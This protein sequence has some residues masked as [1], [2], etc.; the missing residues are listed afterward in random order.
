MSSHGKLS[1]V[2]YSWAV[3]SGYT[4]PAFLFLS[5]FLSVVLSHPPR[6]CLLRRYAL[7]DSREVL[8][9]SPLPLHPVCTLLISVFLGDD[10]PWLSCSLALGGD[11]LCMSLLLMRERERARGN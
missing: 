9:M 2:L 5:S 7:S 3:L 10:S 1:I 8:S 4:S 11:V 6:R